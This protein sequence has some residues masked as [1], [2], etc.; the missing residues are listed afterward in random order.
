MSFLQRLSEFLQSIFSPNSPEAL[1][2]QAIRKIENELRQ[3]APNLYKNGLIQADFAETLRI[4][5][6][7]TSMIGDLLSQTLCSTD[8][9][10]ARRYEEQLLLTGFS[11]EARDILIDRWMK[12]EKPEPWKRIPCRDI[13]KANT[14]SLRK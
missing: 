2:R 10:C 12:T 9:D 13:L 3:L 11:Q 8:I 7:N 6:E 4:L 1:Q 5:Y 14:E